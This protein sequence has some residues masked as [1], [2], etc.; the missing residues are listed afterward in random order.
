MQ[1]CCRATEFSFPQAFECKH[2][3][4][5]PDEDFS[6]LWLGDGD[7][8][9][10]HFEVGSVALHEQRSHRACTREWTQSIAHRRCSHRSVHQADRLTCSRR[11]EPQR[12]AWSEPR[13]Q[14]SSSESKNQDLIQE[15]RNFAKNS[16]LADCI[17]V[18]VV[19]VACRI[20]RIV[21]IR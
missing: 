15:G 12:H 16:F 10:N 11:S 4:H 18:V 17:P 19:P 14:H 8:L 13:I 9:E 1:S 2:R 20:A 3:L 21:R 5:V 7:G 6:A